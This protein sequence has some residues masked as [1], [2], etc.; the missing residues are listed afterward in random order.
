MRFKKFYSLLSLL[1][2][3]AVSATVSAQSFVVNSIGEPV[4][5]LSTLKSGDKVLLFCNGTTDASNA[6]FQTRYAFAKEQD[7]KLVLSRKLYDKKNPANENLLGKADSRNYVFTVGN[8]QSADGTTSLTLQASDKKFVSQF[9]ANNAQATTGDNAQVFTVTP[10]AEGDSLFSFGSTTADGTQVYL[11]GQNIEGGG[12]AADPALLVCWSEAGGNS[13]YMIYKPTVEELKE[14]EIYMSLADDH[15]EYA[16]FTVTYPIGKVLETAPAWGYRDYVDGSVE[17]PLTITEDTPVEWEL[18]YKVRPHISFNYQVVGGESF[19]IADGYYKTGEVVE[20]PSFLGLKLADGQEASYTVGDGDAIVTVNYVSDPTSLPFK[21]STLTEGAFGDEMHWYVLGLRGG[22]KP[23]V[24]NVEDGTLTRNAGAVTAD[25][26]QLFA[27]VGDNGNGFKIYNKAAGAGKSFWAADGNEGSQV[28]LSANEEGTGVD[29]WVI[30]K[31]TSGFVI[32]LLGTGGYI[33]D[34]QGN[35]G[36]GMLRF[37]TDVNDAGSAISFVS[38]NEGPV[39]LT[40][41]TDGKFAENT[42]WYVMKIRGNRFVSYEADDNIKSNNGTYTVG[43]N[44]APVAD[45]FLWAFSGDFISGLTI[46]NKAA[47]ATKAL[48]ASAT[49]GE[50]AITLAEG[51]KSLFL[52]TTNGDGYNIVLNGGTNKVANDV[53]G[54]LAFWEDGAAATDAGSRIQFMTTDDPA[55]VD[56]AIRPYKSYLR[57]V[58]VVS[59]WSAEDMEA[60]GLKA[61]LE[62]RDVAA[63]QEAVARLEVADTIAFDPSKK[64]NLINAYSDYLFGQTDKEI[65]MYVNGEGNVAWSELNAKSED[66]AWT[67][68]PA[69][70]GLYYIVNAKGYV[71]HYSWGVVPKAV[72]A[73]AAAVENGVYAVTDAAPF[74]MFKSAKRASAYIF[75]HSFKPSADSDGFDSV[76]LNTNT[77]GGEANANSTSG[78]IGTYKIDDFGY[79]NAWYLRPVSSEVTGINS[80]VNSDSNADK[81]IYDL[82]GRRVQKVTKGFYIIGGKKVLVK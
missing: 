10:S 17:F 74:S 44:G 63:C 40:T 23:I 79:G 54:K 70:D 28:L 38:R 66:F 43:E 30:E 80:A 77:G 53:Q 69:A 3:F 67:F 52:L 76:W 21:P 4:R 18:N 45:K 37:Y 64:Y 41:V 12:G 19:K 15:D 55:I 68:V 49:A 73:P 82:S 46:Y 8:L 72:E 61:A 60:S 59:G 25:D 48:A 7:G 78:N 6:E 75:V 20:H 42:T 29:K 9:S 57:A 39:S 47:G 32:K 16:D 22:A 62:A 2:F 31:G 5:D 58:N 14:I 34:Y 71:G 13:N 35:N 81:A 33:N 51:S 1:L 36:D 11:N 50:T 26:T 65:A 27:F 24:A 56:A